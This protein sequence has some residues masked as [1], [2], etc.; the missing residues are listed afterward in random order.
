PIN[1]AIMDPAKTIWQTPATSTPTCKQAD[2][3]YFIP[4]KGS[5]FLFTHPAPNSLAV[6]AANQKNKHQFPRSIPTVKDSKRLDLLDRKVYASSTLQFR[7]SNY[8]AILAKYDHK[9]YEKLMHFI[10]DIP[11][12]ER[13]KQTRV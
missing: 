2:R 9:N 3:K 10:D 1:S 5:E 4:S 7:I 11:E 13:N 6:E 12:R 8:S